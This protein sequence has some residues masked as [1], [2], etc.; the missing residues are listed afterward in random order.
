MKNKTVVVTIAA[1]AIVVAGLALWGATRPTGPVANHA[2]SD[3]VWYH[4]SD[5]ALLGRTNKPQLVEFFHPG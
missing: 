4:S 1:A 3:S 5:V 2:P